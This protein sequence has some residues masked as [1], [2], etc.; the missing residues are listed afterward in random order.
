MESCFVDLA[1]V[2]GSGSGSLGDGPG[3]LGCR[4]TPRSRPGD[5][6]AAHARARLLLILDNFEHVPAAAVVVAEVLAA[7]PMVTVLVTSRT[8]L[9]IRAE[10]EYAVGPLALPGSQEALADLDELA[11][12]PAV[13]LF[14][15]RAEVAN[16]RFALT[17]DN[18]AEVAGLVARLDGL[19]LAIELA[20]N[21]M[22]ILSP[23]ALLA[24]MEQRFPLLTRGAHDLP[25]RQQAMRA[26]LDWSHELLSTAEQSL[27]R[28]LA[29]FAGGC[30]VDAA[31]IV[32]AANADHSAAPPLVIDLLADLVD[33]SLLRVVEDLGDD[34]RFGM[35]ET[36]REYGLER[37]AQLGE[38]SEI[39]G[40]HQDWCVALAERAEPELIGASSGDGS[41]G[42]TSNTTTCA[43]RLAGPSRGATSRPPCA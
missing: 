30:T 21:R 39:R 25:V 11:H 31:E 33:K 4:P 15:H 38:E 7:C 40:R 12:V 2:R 28:R 43:S 5:P 9:H 27:F 24:R 3:A 19:P 41:P 20:A 35:L 34:R 22:K 10:R 17:A 8:P 36:I 29:V 18:A 16:P 14:V 23:A 26:T 1:P 6:F 42:W 32:G 13:E 37:L